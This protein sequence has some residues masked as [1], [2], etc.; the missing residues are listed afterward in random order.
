MPLESSMLPSNFHHLQ[1]HDPQLVRLGMLAERYF[2]DDPNTCLLKLR[3]L[4]EWLAQMVA[5]RVGVRVHEDDKQV[6]LIRRLQDQGIVPREVASLFH[7]V[8]KV[9]NDANHKLAGDHRS[10]LLVLRLTWQLGVWFHRT[11]KD[12]AFKSGAFLPPV[13]PKDE[14]AEL[15]AELDKLRAEMETQRASQEGHTEVLGQVAARARQAEE[16]RAFW[17][18]M[19]AEAESAKAELHKQLAALQAQAQAAPPQTIANFVSAANTAATQIQISES[20]TRKRID[21][22][23]VATGWSAD[24][25]A[26]THALGARPERGKNLAIAEWP[27]RDGV[28]DYV[29]FIGLLPVAAIEAKRQN[30]DVSSAL[31]QAKRYSCGFQVASEL[32]S[33]GGPWG[34]H[35]LPFVFSSNGRPYLRQLAT[36]SGIW[37]C[38]LRRPENLARALD[39]WYTPDGLLALL[40][41]DDGSAQAKLQ[42]QPFTY[43][44]PLRAYQQT[45]IQAV[46]TAIGQGARTLLLAMA[47]GTGKTKTCIALIYRLLKAQRFRRILF[48]V[49]RSALGE[50]AAN[51]FKDT[52]MENLQTFADVFGIKE[53]EEQKPD[54]DT[55]VHIATVQGL[56]QRVLYPAEN[57]S[58]LPVDAYD[59]IVVDECHRGYLLDR[60]LSDTELGFRS[61]DDYVS[62]Y[63]RVLEYF[64]AVKIGLTATPALHTTQIF[65][66]PVYSYSYREAVIDGFLVDHEPPVQIRTALSTSGI[67]WRVGEQVTVYNAPQS[68]L[69]LFETPDELHFEIEHFNRQVISESFNRVVCDYLATELDPASLQKTLVFCVND[70]HADQVVD[71]LKQ[72]FA[73]RWGSVED[74]AVLKITGAADKPLQLIRRFKNERLPN[75]AVTVDLLTTGVDVPAICNLVFL[76]RVN[77]RI[78]FDQM[79]GRATRLCEPIGK[80]AF[81]IFD[82]VRI[83]E[84]LQHMTAMQPVVVDPQLSF[85]QLGRELATVTDE[86]AR[87]LVRDQFVA[88]LR[89][90]ERHLSEA[91]RQDFET[92]AGMP[93]AAFVRQLQTLPLEQIAGW[94]TQHPELGEI[95][96]RKGQVGASRIFV[97]GHEDRLVGTERGYGA[98]TRP[99]DYLDAFATY[100]SQRGNS[101]PA[102][103]TV[104]TR[105]RELTRQQLRELALALDRAGFPEA[106]L[107]TAWRELTN[108]DIAA[109]IVGYIRQ[110][111][112]GDPLVP[113][114]QRVD[115]ALQTILGSRV[116]TAPQRTWLQKIAAQTKA[117]LVVDRSAIDDPDQLFRRDG[118]GFARLDKLFDGGLENVLAQFNEA[119]WP[120]AA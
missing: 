110:A 23:L 92:A 74:D 99:Q 86:A 5:A 57:A 15:R 70:A 46:E 72:A 60:E 83:Y 82:A 101:L 40:K 39:N 109:R 22:Q 45:A 3:Q 53:L 6:D 59:C 98:A 55:K 90:K 61:F 103:L 116:W 118:G 37:F 12:P 85:T 41:R 80:E 112:I 56:V 58:P 29:L 95:L 30:L 69:E 73:Q 4:A 119:L 93:P 42:T 96:D 10:A 51:A 68:Q 21:A 44:F 62:S 24:S 27:T 19:A 87:G 106:S 84:T 66:P 17:E 113:Y 108:Q 107:S 25:A 18:Q 105:P 76:R 43:G 7:D 14:S 13:A 35:G 8:R 71:L 78:L 104:L 89:R 114:T 20:D 47:T 33:P 65:G 97:S 28:A 50:Q 79:L 120:P 102:L 115:R 117:N 36:R 88:K 54:A 9:G 94:F 48:L 31:Q 64:D 75:V 52:R 100:L 38:D 16:E 63:R 49:D 77:S 111:A 11:F 2:P 91:Q 32:L 34:E 67:T 81:R 26:L 1:A